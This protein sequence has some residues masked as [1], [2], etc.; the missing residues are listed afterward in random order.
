MNNQS[1][2]ELISYY[3]WPITIIAFF[4]ALIIFNSYLMITALSRQPELVETQP[5]EKGLHYQDKINKFENAI[6]WGLNIK[7]QISDP[8]SEDRREIRVN[9]SSNHFGDQSP[10]RV[11]VKAT[12]SNDSKLDQ[13]VDLSPIDG[14]VGSYGSVLILPP[15]LWQ[16]EIYV[17]RRGQ[18]GLIKKQLLLS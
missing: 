2:I 7:L 3:R 10:Q 4:I 6:N 18:E 9:V 11:K 13:E 12:R 16:F 1:L 5:Y 8:M 14:E 15:G 17:E